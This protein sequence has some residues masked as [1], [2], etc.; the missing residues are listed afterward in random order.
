MNFAVSTA[1]PLTYIA[2]QNP[3][4]T[5]VQTPYELITLLLSVAVFS[6]FPDIDEPESKISRY[7]FVKPFSLLLSLFVKHRAFTHRLCGILTFA[8]ILAISIFFANQYTNSLLPYYA[9]VGALF[10]YIMHIM[11]DAMTLSGIR[12]F[13]CTKKKQ[14]TL[15]I[16]P[17]F[18]RFRTFSKTESIYNFMFL[19]IMAAE[20][21]YIFLQYDIKEIISFFTKALY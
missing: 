12:N 9:A 1:I 8:L 15:F 7:W 14:Y 3:Y 6:L 17:K 10:G 18:M 13:F 16:L 4:Y 11:G 2:S 5:L 21:I 20:V 19:M